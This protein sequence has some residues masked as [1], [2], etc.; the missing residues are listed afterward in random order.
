MTIQRDF[1]SNK[2]FLMAYPKSSCST[3]P[4]LRLQMNK[5]AVV[6]NPGPEAVGIR[7]T[8]LLSNCQIGKHDAAKNS[9]SLSRPMTRAN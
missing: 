1:L 9:G 5:I 8:F 3:T 2:A 4:D 7:T 6:N